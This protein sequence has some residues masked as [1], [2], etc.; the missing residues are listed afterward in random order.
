MSDS[1]GYS[2][3]P[4]RPDELG[5]L[6]DIERAAAAIFSATAF[7][8]MADAALASEHVA[9]DRDW[10]WLT[11]GPDGRPVAF[12]IA[13]PL[14]DGAHLHELDVHPSHARRGL[15]R[16]LIEAVAV[17]AAHEG[18]HAF[19]LTTF[20]EIPW[21]APYYARLGF[22]ALAEA[23]LSPALQAILRAEVAAGLPGVARTAMRRELASPVAG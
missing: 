5:L 3:R 19:T 17:R 20:R 21:N 10:V 15:G 23:E 12:V 9:H 4:A 6:P 18:A 11:V 1:D 22:R 14:A 8:E 7:P 16:L 13:H 2:V